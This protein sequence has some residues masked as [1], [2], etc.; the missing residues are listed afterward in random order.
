MY[1][2]RAA[3]HRGL[4]SWP[5][6]NVSEM[7]EHPL[8]ECNTGVCS[9]EDLYCKE[10]LYWVCLL[11]IRI[12]KKIHSLQQPLYSQEDLYSNISNTFNKQNTVEDLYCEESPLRIQQPLLWVCSFEDLYC[13]SNIWGVSRPTH[14]EGA[15]A[16]RNE[17][18]IRLF[19][20]LGQ[21]G[22]LARGN[23]PAATLLATPMRAPFSIHQTTSG[24]SFGW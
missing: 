14:L 7:L 10:D 22:A 3:S 21:Y 9:F 8:W 11:K 16:P 4:S 24:R 19:S 20:T 13:K 18:R 12:L 1:C 23:S 2:G 15:D 6:T 17:N 5:K